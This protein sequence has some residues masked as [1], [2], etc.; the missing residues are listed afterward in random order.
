MKFLK[1]SF[2]CEIHEIHEKEMLTNPRL[3]EEDAPEDHVVLQ[4]EVQKAFQAKGVALDHLQRQ[5]LTAFTSWRAFFNM[6][7][8]TTIE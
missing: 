6:A 4:A 5:P 2:G 3:Q 7:E 8:P 1:N